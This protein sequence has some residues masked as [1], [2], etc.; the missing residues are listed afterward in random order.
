[1][2]GEDGMSEVLYIMGSGRSGTTILEVLLANSPGTFGAGELTHILRDGFRDDGICSCGRSTSNCDVW[3]HVRRL[4]GWRREDLPEAIRLLRRIESHARFPLTVAG[5]IDGETLR[6]YRSLNR[7]LLDAVAEV[8]GARV[9]IDSS[10]YAGRALALSQCFPERVRVLN[11][12]RSPA[13]LLGAFRK[14]RRDEQ[15]QKSMVGALLYHGYVLMSLNAARRRLG[16]RSLDVRYDDLV[17]DPIATI[18]RVG[19][20]WKRDVSVT[21]RKLELGELF[22]VGHIVTGNRLRYQGRVRFDPS[23]ASVQP[24]G[25]IGRLVIRVMELYES[26]LAR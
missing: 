2:P 12:T 22:D 7:R 18:R 10:K 5:L 3:S 20:W 15:K 8:T 21:L 17:S 14:P 19:E 9:I 13:G 4:G 1:M 11:V 16:P 24:A 25:P 6:A 23:A 26:M